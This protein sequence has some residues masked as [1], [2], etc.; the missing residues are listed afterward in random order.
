MGHIVTVEPKRQD[1]RVDV[2][3]QRLDPVARDRRVGLQEGVGAAEVV[4]PRRVGVHVVLQDVLT[5]PPRTREPDRVEREVRVEA[6]VGLVHPIVPKGPEQRGQRAEDDGGQHGAR[7]VHVEP[8]ANE[9]HEVEP[10]EHHARARRPAVRTAH[11]AEVLRQPPPA[12][13]VERVVAS[14][15]GRAAHRVAGVGFDGMVRGCMHPSDRRVH[16]PAEQ[17]V[18]CGHLILCNNGPRLL[19][20]MVVRLERERGVLEAVARETDDLLAARMLLQEGL[21][22]VPLPADPPQFP[23]GRVKWH[24]RRPDSGARLHLQGC[25]VG[26]G[27][28]GGAGA[29]AGRCPGPLRRRLPRV[30]LAHSWGLA[31]DA[32]EERRLLRTPAFGEPRSLANTHTVKAVVGVDLQSKWILLV[33]AARRRSP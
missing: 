15:L 3:R 19:V 24:A 22:V 16:W 28:R 30:A 23:R 32:E 13:G 20:V 27:V 14:E 26:R 11:L 7:L 29:V 21:E 12:D 5:E 25:R 1:D 10:E 6:V 17:H 18:G 2:G 31:H 33:L 9:A 4:V 8:S